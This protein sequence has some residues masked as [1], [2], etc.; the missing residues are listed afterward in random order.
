MRPRSHSPGDGP[1]RL[2]RLTVD[3]AEVAIDASDSADKV[4]FTTGVIVT[5]N[6]DGTGVTEISDG[7][8]PSWS[9]AGNRIA[10]SRNRQPGCGYN[11]VWVM[12]ADGSDKTLLDPRGWSAQWSPDGRM[13]AYYGVSRTCPD[14]ADRDEGCGS[15]FNRPAVC[16]V[17]EGTHR[18][19]FTS[20][21]S[22]FGMLY[23]NFDW[24]PDSRR[25]AIQARM[26][27]GTD[28]IAVVDVF[29]G[30]DWLELVANEPYG[31][32]YD[33]HPDGLGFLATTTVEGRRSLIRVTADGSGETTPVLPGLPAGLSP[34]D[35]VYTPD[36]NRVLVA[37]RA[38]VPKK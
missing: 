3:G 10:V 1:S 14:P 29:A 6:A 12:N 13:I 23:W 33:W 11:S 27:E 36:G 17:V 35:A 21:E 7:N 15:N 8:M 37:L 31:M 9:P 16:E 25:V 22:P 26:P 2:G 34:H 28:V 20:A 4:H 5:M 30:T 18:E 32:T 19:V 24:A 38:D